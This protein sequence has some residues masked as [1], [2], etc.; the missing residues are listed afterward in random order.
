M[1]ADEKSGVQILLTGLP[2]RPTVP[3][4]LLQVEFEYERL[5]TVAYHAALDV[6]RGKILGQVV[7]TTSI[8]TFNQL[9]DRVMRQEPYQS[10]ERVFWLVD[11]GCAYHRST[12]FS[13]LKGLY[14]NALAVL[15]PV[16]SSWLNQ[17]ELYFSIVQRK[18][19]TPL[20]VANAALKNSFSS[21]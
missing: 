1:S 7:N 10:D 5:G 21:R 14:P 17:I 3:G 13:R 6:F 9:L 19:L 2:S 11:G 20:D 16:H 18:V 4:H 12:F 15:L 8:A